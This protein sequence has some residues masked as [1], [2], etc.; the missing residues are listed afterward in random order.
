MRLEDITLALFAACNFIRVFAYIPQIHKAATDVN[1]ASAISCTTWALFLIAHVSTVAYALVNRSDWWLAACFASNALCC[2]AIL[3]I[4]YWKGRCLAR[5][6]SR[7]DPASPLGPAPG[8]PLRFRQGP[9]RIAGE[10]R[11]DDHLSAQRT[12]DF[13]ADDALSL[14]GPDDRHRPASW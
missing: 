10:V 8:Q 14:A 3:A 7:A 6:K 2:I 12:K 5:E 13:A 1:G 4:A 9:G 11:S